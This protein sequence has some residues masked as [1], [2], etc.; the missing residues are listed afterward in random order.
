M[1]LRVASL[2]VPRAVGAFPSPGPVGGRPVVTAAPIAVVA[3]VE[4]EAEPATVA[5]E[6]PP[7]AAGFGWVGT[8]PDDPAVA[9]SRPPL[10]RTALLAAAA[11]GLGLLLPDLY[12][13][14]PSLRRRWPVLL[15]FRRSPRPGTGGGEE[16]SRS[17]LGLAA[18]GLGAG[19]AVARVSSPQQARPRPV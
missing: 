19:R 6:P 11:I 2:R 13:E 9:P 12:A 8:T 15:P 16:P 17:P 18:R 4:A 5:T 1:P 3:A 7:I 10:V 14:R